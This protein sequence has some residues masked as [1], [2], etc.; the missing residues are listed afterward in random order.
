MQEEYLLIHK[1]EAADDQVALISCER[2]DALELTVVDYTSSA[3]SA[4]GELDATNFLGIG[5][6]FGIRSGCYAFYE[7]TDD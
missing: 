5:N 3:T 7:V 2:Y 4:D 6:G 1:M